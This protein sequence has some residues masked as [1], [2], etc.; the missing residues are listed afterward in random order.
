MDERFD[1]TV[2]NIQK[3]QLMQELLDCNDM[4]IH[5]GLSLSAQQIQNLIEKRFQALK[6]TGRIEFGQ[7]VLVK[8]ITEFCNSPYIT[9]DNY[10]DT[11]MELQDSFFYF[12]NESIDQVSDEELILTMKRY[13]DG[14]CQ[15]S[16][17]RLSDTTLE[18]LCR[19]IRY[20]YGPDESEE[21]DESED[22]DE[23]DL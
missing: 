2:G 9:Q 17:D 13:F 20:G 6:D 7:G 5:Y 12:K 14:I 8:I 4:T 19:G 21:L 18:D 15:G 3:V 1:M 22:S 16:L 23:S 11:I 10:E